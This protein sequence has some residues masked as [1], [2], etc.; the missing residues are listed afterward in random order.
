MRATLISI[1]NILTAALAFLKLAGAAFQISVLP[2]GLEDKSLV[3]K[4]EGE[5]EGEVI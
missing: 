4:G 1:P 2:K 5:G 3:V